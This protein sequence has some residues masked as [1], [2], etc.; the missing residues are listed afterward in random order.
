MQVKLLD[1]STAVWN[2]HLQKRSTAE[3]KSSFH[4]SARELIKQIY[5]TLTL[6]E[7]VNI[8]LNKKEIAF[9]DFYLPLLKLGL[10]VQGQQHY[11]F[12]A[13]FHKD[14][15]DLLW[16]KLKDKRKREWCSLNGIKLIELSYKDSPEDW[17]RQITV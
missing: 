7:E 8:P 1:G 9:L 12:S 13:H 2:P 11:K 10:E 17:K 14:Q 6:L 4:L 3:N 15:R 16:Q 5:P